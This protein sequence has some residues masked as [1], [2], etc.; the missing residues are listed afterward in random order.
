MANLEAKT[1]SA[2][3]NDKQIHVLLQAGVG[4]ILRTHG[5]VW[6][7]IA[8]YYEQ[9]QS[10]PPATVVVKKF[11]DF[12][13][14]EDTGATKHHLEEL[15]TKF[16][17]DRIK[18]LLQETAQTVK[19]GEPNIALDSLISETATLKRL[20]AATR[21]LDVSDVDDAIAHFELVKRLQESG[22]YGIYTGLA[23]FDNYLPSGIT[24]G[25][26]G[27]FLAYPG[28]GKS[29]MAVYFAVQAWKMGKSP[30]IVSLEMSEEEVRNRAFTVIGNGMWSHRKLSS[31]QVEI[32][33][34]KK[35]M[36]RTFDGKPPLRI[37]SN[38]GIGEVT[39]SVLRGK[40]D[41]YHPDI[42]FVDY[43]NLMSP[44]QKADN[45]T[46][47]VKNLSRELKLLA[48]MESIP[49]VAISSATPGENTDLTAVPTLDQVRWSKDIAYDADWLLALGRGQNSDVIECVF[50]KN[51]N[52]H[53]GDFMVQVD[54]DSG[55][56][57]YK[58]FE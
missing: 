23:G 41:Q 54:F 50:R 22:T 48:G 25:Q 20:S 32:D 57:V 15:R 9:N 6:D 7:F 1:L 31:G 46:V 28:I 10:L 44:N 12:E 8:N 3:L 39:P 26:L 2:V 17:E 30:L 29:W 37:I 42:V 35:W 33:M 18:L 53:L 38:D 27:V 5:D 45:E 47:R 13:Y 56:F 36:D 21:D 16:L 51:R 11:P 43:L 14:S 52:G 19:S 49:I 55:R 34:M 4:N 58:D 24:P 40:I